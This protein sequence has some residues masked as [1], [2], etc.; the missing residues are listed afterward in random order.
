MEQIDNSITEADQNIDD[1]DEI[2][3]T[4]DFARLRKRRSPDP[5]P[6]GVRKRKLKKMKR[7]RPKTVV[8]KMNVKKITKPGDKTMYA[9][10]DGSVLFSYPRRSN[11]RI[12]FI[13]KVLVQTMVLVGTVC[14]F[15]FVYVYW[16]GKLYTDE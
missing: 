14:A 7:K 3:D 2:D 8:D 13:G 1:D 12:N 11:A 10:H 4:I 5:D 15:I 9:V 16:Y 6:R